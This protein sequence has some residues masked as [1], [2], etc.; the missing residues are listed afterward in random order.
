MRLRILNRKEKKKFLRECKPACSMESLKGWEL[1][2]GDGELCY[3][4]RKFMNF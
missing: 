1:L 3:I 4:L 2:E